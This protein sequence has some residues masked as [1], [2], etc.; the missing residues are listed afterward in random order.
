MF[1]DQGLVTGCS[2][3]LLLGLYTLQSRE[4]RSVL[5]TA[6]LC[7][8]CSGLPV[9]SNLFSNSKDPQF[10]AVSFLSKEK[11]VTFVLVSPV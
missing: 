3:D 10:F 5:T 8:A 7:R 9:S 11:K 4:R 6:P 2:W 1:R